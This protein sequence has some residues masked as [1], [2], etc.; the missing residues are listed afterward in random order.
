[1]D[2]DRFEVKWRKRLS[3][4]RI[5]DGREYSREFKED[6]ITRSE[7][8]FRWGGGGEGEVVVSGDESV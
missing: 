6:G 4:V 7:S 2:D 5:N 3:I 8:G 1:M